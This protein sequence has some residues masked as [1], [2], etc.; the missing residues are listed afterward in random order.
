MFLHHLLMEEP[1][2]NRFVKVLLGCR[3]AVPI[4][5][6]HHI[7]S[8]P[9]NN[10]LRWYLFKECLPSITIE[11][12]GQKNWTWMNINFLAT[13]DSGCA[14]CGLLFSWLQDIVDVKAHIRYH[15]NRTRMSGGRFLML[16]FIR[17]AS[18]RCCFFTLLCL[19]SMLSLML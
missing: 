6:L 17:I 1:H 5:V 11:F 10:E 18:V 12:H 15:G 16:G 13:Y 8:D 19:V 7:L 4:M 14:G 9:A 3:D 2:Q